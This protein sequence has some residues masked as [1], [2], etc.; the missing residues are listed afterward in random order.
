MIFPPL[1]SF[2]DMST[3]AHR[4]QLNLPTT[5]RWPGPSSDEP[6]PGIGESLYCCA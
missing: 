5:S 2:L 4:I 1:V 6:R 3:A